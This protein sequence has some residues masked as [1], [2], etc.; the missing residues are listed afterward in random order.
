MTIQSQQPY[1][2]ARF[3][4]LE[5]VRSAGLFKRHGVEFGIIRGRPIFHSNRAGVK[6]T[7]GAGSGKTSQIALPMIMG[8]DASFVLLDTKNAEITRVIEPHCALKGVPL[9]VIDPFGVSDYPSARVSLLPYLKP[10]SPS[11][12]PDSQRFWMALLP[13]SSGDHS[14]FEQAGRRFGDAITR[15][16]VHLNGSSSLQSIADILAHLRSDYDSWASWADLASTRSSPDIVAT[17]GEMK[18]MYGGSPKTF[19]SV[20]GG[21]SNALSFMATP[22]IRETF[23]SDVAADFAL[24]DVI[25]DTR[26]TIISLIIPEELL[27]PLAPVVRQY[28]S[29][30]RSIK[31]RMPSAPSV[32]FMIDEAARLGRFKEL[33]ELFAVG[34]GQ[35]ITPYAFYQDDGQ[36]TRNLGMTGKATIEA[37]AALMIDLGGGIRDYETARNR[38]LTLGN[39]TI[40]LDDP[41]IQ[42]RADAQSRE[43]MRQVHLEGAD[44]MQ[45]GLRLRQLDYEAGHRTKMRKALMEP[46]QLLGLDPS[47]MLVQARGYHLRPFIAEKSP[48][49]VQRRFAGH[50]FPNPNE[51][52]DLNSVLLQSFIRSRRR[53]IVELPAPHGLSDLPQYAGGRPLRYVEGFKPKF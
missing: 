10:N 27:E 42:S 39:Q 13:D 17:F 9:Y 5:E 43:I 8:S 34:R 6:I 45:A 50:F 31:Q 15:H 32:N 7:G 24:A 18:D 51:D 16:D 21:V 25:A 47:K 52:R 22:A 29:A 40:Q 48:Y 19:D 41:L 14:F 20:M 37:N 36:I 11:L 38:S 33:E 35:G 4:S 12:V 2:D 23:V 30:I 44:P 3:A 46:E 28:F 1:G 26:K 53:R 49:F